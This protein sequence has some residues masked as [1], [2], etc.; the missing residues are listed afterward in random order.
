[1]I[2]SRKNS[3]TTK[4]MYYLPIGIKGDMMHDLNNYY[5]YPGVRR[6]VPNILVHQE[7]LVDKLSQ[8][9]EVLPSDTV[10]GYSQIFLETCQSRIPFSAV[11]RSRT[12][13]RFP[14]KIYK[15]NLPKTWHRSN[16]LPSDVAYLIFWRRLFGNLSMVSHLTWWILPPTFR[17]TVPPFLARSFA[18]I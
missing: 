14:L 6:S 5:N 7:N 8:W 4:Y 1:M 12:E 17:I 9:G 11:S 16:N 2:N 10:P 15:Q 3:D 18:K 13:I